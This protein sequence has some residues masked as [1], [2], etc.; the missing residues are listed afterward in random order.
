M[1]V[2]HRAL[3]LR[4]FLLIFKELGPV[5][6]SCP[7]LMQYWPSSEENNSGFNDLFRQNEGI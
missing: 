4:G 3:S 6:Y 2:F 1:V 5:S 7:T